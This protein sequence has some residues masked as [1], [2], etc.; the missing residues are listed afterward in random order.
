MQKRK[1]INPSI[2]NKLQLDKVTESPPDSCTIMMHDL[3]EAYIFLVN[4]CN[5]S[6]YTKERD[7]I[8][9]KSHFRQ[10]FKDSIRSSVLTFP[11]K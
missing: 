5:L 9:L 1:V 11:D 10:N 7:Y 2:K 6:Y 8:E 3:F 4:E